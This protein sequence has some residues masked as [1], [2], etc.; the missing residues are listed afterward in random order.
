MDGAVS[1]HWEGGRWR[2]YKTRTHKG[3][4]KQGHIRGV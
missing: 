3:S 1:I 2:E 4:I